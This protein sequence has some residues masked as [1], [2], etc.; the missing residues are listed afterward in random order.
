MKRGDR[1]R[2][3]RRALV[4]LAAAGALALGAYRGAASLSAALTSMAEAR[5]RQ[6]AA[7]ALNGALQY[8]L[9]RTLTYAD[10]VDVRADGQG[11][12][13][14]LAA[15]TMLMDALAAEAVAQA[16]ARIAALGEKGVELPLGAALGS[17]VFSGAGPRVRFAVVPVG[18]VTADFVTEFQTAGIN[19]TRHTIFLE[20]EA[21][22]QIVIPTG[23]APISVRARLPIAESILVGEVPESYIQVPQTEDALNF[24]P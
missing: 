7:D 1:P 22:V 19:Q 3:L 13:E 16:Q 2:R 20:A 21:R 4:L 12:V 15:N 10:F 14:L 17:G 24:A 9:D 5:A 8:M 6:L 11:R 23:S 18:T